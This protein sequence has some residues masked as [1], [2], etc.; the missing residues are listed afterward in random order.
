MSMSVADA[1]GQLWPQCFNEVAEVIIGKT[2]GEMENLKENNTPEYDATFA[3]VMLREGIFKM[4][5]KT[6][7]YND[8]GRVR[9]GIIGYTPVNFA[10]DSELL[11][12]EIE[13]MMAC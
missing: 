12:R 10:A 9:Y 3:N 8:E 5:A 11:T 1:Y 13:S 6:E 4:R 7:M 2:A